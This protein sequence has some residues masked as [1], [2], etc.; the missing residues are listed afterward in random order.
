MFT[1]APPRPHIIAKVEQKKTSKKKSQP[2]LYLTDFLARHIGVEPTAFRLGVLF[3]CQNCIKY[4]KFLDFRA[5]YAIICVYYARFLAKYQV[6][7]AFN[8]NFNTK[9]YAKT[10]PIL[11]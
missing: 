3:E 5:F 1:K 2:K 4:A 8:T 6:I 11:I 10:I 7:F 9:N